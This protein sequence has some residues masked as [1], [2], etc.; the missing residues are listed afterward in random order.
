MN[1]PGGSPS[2]RESE[3][4]DSLL[5]SVRG[6]LGL[7]RRARSG[8]TVR[9]ALEELIED[10]DD[11]ESPI[12]AHER[13]L[14]GN[15]LHLRGVTAADVKVPRADIVAVESRTTQ[16]ELIRL[17]IAC[18]HSRLPVYRRTLDDV[19]GMVHIKD[20]LEIL[21]QGKPFSL[22]RMMRRVQFVAPSMRATDLLLEMRL[23]RNHLALVVDEYGGIDGLVTIEDLVEQIVGDIADEHDHI[24]DADMVEL[25]DGTLEADARTAIED[26][27]E[28]MGEVLT[29]EEREEVETLG[30]LV[31]F[32]AGRVPG[33]GELINHSTGLEFEV[34][35]ADPRRVKRV[36]V[37]RVPLDRTA[38]PQPD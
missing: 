2:Q 13:Q 30:G 33:R 28:R 22:P 11:S 32:V 17:F 4:R 36:R 38:S 31:S 27:E 5:R 20:L 9:E 7:K 15:I 10:R 6:W 25:A 34:M 35:D 23:R 8:E 24:E 18:G 21:G 37:R 16:E 14:L 26:F 12:D 3:P 1:D 29:D 19:I